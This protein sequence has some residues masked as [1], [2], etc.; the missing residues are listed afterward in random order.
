MSWGHLSSGPNQK[1]GSAPM[2]WESGINI[3]VHHQRWIL[4]NHA[5]I[6]TR[7]L[8]FLSGV[9]AAVVASS[10]VSQAADVPDGKT[11]PA[12]VIGSENC[13]KCHKS[14]LAAL[15]ASKHHNSLAKLSGGNAAKY[16]AAVGGGKDLCINCHGTPKAGAADAISGVSC[17]SCH[18][19]A[20]D[21]VEIHG[22][23]G[24]ARADRHAGGDK[25]GMIR[26]SSV[27]TIAKNC[28]Q[29]HVVFN[30]KLVNA[31]HPASNKIDFLGW[32]TGEVRHN[33][34]KDQST[35]ADAPSAWTEYASGKVENRRRVKL[36]VGHLVDLEVCLNNMGKAEELKGD[37]AKAA[38]KRAK[39]AHGELEDIAKDLGGDAPA[40]LK[41]AIA[42]VDDLGRL[43]ALSVKAAQKAAA[44]G[45]AA[46]V[47]AAAAAISEKY[48]GSTLSG[49][50]D[51]VGK[52]KPQGTPFKP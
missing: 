13:A 19:G 4:M 11:D 41:A 28:F 1:C 34:Q 20:K 9:A 29:C 21:W 25:G 35:N 32:S 36:I 38:S 24:V 39:A 46:K 6:V 52:A 37:Y 33:F 16:M 7:R 2:E 42:A 45:V 49:V 23:E 30:E 3:A 10:V 43:S 5:S 8:L 51:L 22:K 14:E 47:A 48:D 18:G 44:P 40:E 31:G 15:G 12:Q 27:Y 26:A 17:E 50:D